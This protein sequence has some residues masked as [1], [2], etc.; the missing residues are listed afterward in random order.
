MGF[1]DK[2]SN[3]EYLWLNKEGAVGYGANSN[4]FP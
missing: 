4:A 1:V 2:E 3:E